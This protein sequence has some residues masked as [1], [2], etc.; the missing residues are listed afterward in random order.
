MGITW[1]FLMV[2]RFLQVNDMKYLFLVVAY[3]CFF[4]DDL[5]ANVCSH[6]YVT[7]R[8]EFRN[9]TS[10]KLNL[11]DFKDLE[12][13][14]IVFN[15]REFV[16]KRQR[17]RYLHRCAQF[18]TI[19]TYYPSDLICIYSPEEQDPILILKEYFSFWMDQSKK[20]LKIITADSYVPQSQLPFDEIVD[21]VNHLRACL[22]KEWHF[23]HLGSDP[24]NLTSSPVQLQTRVP[25]ILLKGTSIS[26]KL[27]GKWVK[28]GENERR[29]ILPPLLY[30]E[31]KKWI[32]ARPTLEQVQ[33][34]VEDLGNSSAVQECK[35]FIETLKT[36]GCDDSMSL[37]EAYTKVKE[38][39]SA[40]QFLALFCNFHHDLISDAIFQSCQRGLSRKSAFDC[41]LAIHILEEFARL[42]KHLEKN[43]PLL[44]F[45]SKVQSNRIAQPMSF[46]FYLEKQEYRKVDPYGFKFNR[47]PSNPSV[48]LLN[49]FAR[50]YE[51]FRPEMLKLTKEEISQVYED[52]YASVE[53]EINYTLPLEKKIRQ[54]TGESEI[55]QLVNNQ[56]LHLFSQRDGEAIVLMADQALNCLKDS[57]GQ[58][59]D[60]V[61]KDDIWKTYFDKQNSWNSYFSLTPEPFYAPLIAWYLVIGWINEYDNFFV[62][63]PAGWFDWTKE[64]FIDTYYTREENWSGDDIR[65]KWW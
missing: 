44:K 41:L 65:G 10:N 52:Q 6:N 40:S 27:G 4:N 30:E 3:L 58:W 54:L 35:D 7:N 33:Q 39:P 62:Q 46:E 55:G 16:L 14:R 50:I 8:L 21:F 9:S 38:T 26:E 36:Y 13:E 64:H 48:F 25:N 29:E 22:S 59:P 61:N 57:K 18:N 37:R 12:A 60:S 34:G 31:G 47:Y 11:A 1:S 24:V 53:A 56:K 19:I 49:S 15:G 17:T 42:H 23:L 32:Q 51:S 2:G 63:L 28:W 20:T 43:H 45:S 5:G